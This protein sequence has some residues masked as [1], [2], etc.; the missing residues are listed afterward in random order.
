MTTLKGTH[1]I[2]RCIHCWKEH[3][4]CF[5]IYKPNSVIILDNGITVVSLKFALLCR[6]G[7]EFE[8]EPEEQYDEEE[9]EAIDTD[10]PGLEGKTFSCSATVY[11]PQ[12]S[13]SIPCHEH[14]AHLFIFPALFIFYRPRS[15]D[16]RCRRKTKRRKYGPYYHQIL[17]KI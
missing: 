8:E 7:D 12:L 11:H 15:S 14:L 5:K 1:E 17:N 9:D 6:F 16:I 4:C 10:H 3:F 13:V 2:I